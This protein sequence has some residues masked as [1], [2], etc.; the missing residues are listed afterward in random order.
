[1]DEIQNYSYIASN[2]AFNGFWSYQY[3]GVSRANLAL[4][5]LMDDKIIET[6][7]MDAS[8]RKRLLGE[9]Y[10]LRAF[11]YFDLVYELLVM[12]LF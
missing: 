6:V 7:G 12:F 3:E 8:L 9:T 2:T 1:M 10:F 5:Y 11:Y 4:S